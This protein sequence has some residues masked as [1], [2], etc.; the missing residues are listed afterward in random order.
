MLDGLAPALGAGEAKRV[1]ERRREGRFLRATAYHIEQRD[2]DGALLL[3]NVALHGAATLPWVNNDRTRSEW[4]H[5]SADNVERLEDLVDQQQLVASW[6]VGME[7]AKTAQRAL[8]STAT[9][10]EKDAAVAAVERWR[11]AAKRRSGL[12]PR[13]RRRRRRMRPWPR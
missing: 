12:W 9:A 11:R 10:A 7:R 5:P 8:A 3:L 4:L 1:I 6:T 2:T 13:P